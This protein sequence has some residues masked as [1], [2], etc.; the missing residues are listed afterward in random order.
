MTLEVCLFVVVVLTNLELMWV[1]GY[2][3]D[4]A[5]KVFGSLNSGAVKTS[6]APGGHGIHYRTLG[7]VAYFIS[8]LNTSRKVMRLVEGR[9]WAVLTE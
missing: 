5:Q 1:L 7:N 2:G 3:S 9:I 8:S 6:E 4:T